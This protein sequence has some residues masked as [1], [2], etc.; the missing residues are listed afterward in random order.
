MA[1]FRKEHFLENGLNSLVILALELR[2]VLN[3]EKIHS[4]PTS[5]SSV[6]D[7]KCD[8]KNFPTDAQNVARCW[9]EF[10]QGVFLSL[11]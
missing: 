1:E 4:Y 10:Q 2:S 6:K 5:R 11:S 7:C 9:T 8:Q 3:V